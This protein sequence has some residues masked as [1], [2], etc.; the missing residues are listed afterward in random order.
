MPG[1]LFSFDGVHP[2]NRGHAAVVNETIEVINN[3]YGAGIPL[4]DALRVG[5]AR[6]RKMA[7]SMLRERLEGAKS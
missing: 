5:R 7:A 2:S 4:V 1:E 6:E 3:T